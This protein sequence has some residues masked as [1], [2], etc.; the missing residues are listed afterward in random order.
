MRILLP[1]ET[2]V[3]VREK[4]FP[5]FG[6]IRSKKCY[7]IDNERERKQGS[8]RWQSEEIMG[9][10]AILMAERA[11]RKRKWREVLKVIK[12]EQ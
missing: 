3:P 12:E 1:G 6:N 7:S 9:E 5:V 2:V 8:T 11:A 10:A 4:Y